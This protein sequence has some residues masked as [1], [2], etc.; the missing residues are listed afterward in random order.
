[1]WIRVYRADNGQS[2][3]TATFSV[4]AYNNGDGWYLMYIGYGQSFCVGAPGYQTV[5]GNTDSYSSMWAALSPPPPPASNC[6]CWS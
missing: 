3:T 5:C 2:I 1:M 4:T 6:N